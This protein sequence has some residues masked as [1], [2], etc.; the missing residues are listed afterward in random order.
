MAD[1]DR[2]RGLRGVWTAL[3]EAF[4]AF[5][6]D[7]VPQL[8]AALAFSAI[9]AIA[10]F[11]IIAIALGSLFFGRAEVR[12]EILRQ[13][14]SYVGP[15]AAEFVDGLIA[16]A[17]APVASIPAA[18]FGILAVLFTA[19]GLFGLLQLTLNQIWGVKP[20]PGGGIKRL[21][22]TRI[23]SFLMVLALGVLILLTLGTSTA[24]S[25]FTRLVPESLPASA[26]LLELANFAA[27][28]V[29]TTVA[30]ALIY[31]IL[32][33]VHLSF[34]DVFGGALI[35]ALIFNVGQILIGLYIAYGSLASIYGAA[36]SLV[37]ILIW[38]YFSAQVF[39]YGAELTQVFAR[40][41]GSKM[42]PS[43]NAQ[44]VRHLIPVKP[45]S[46]ER[47]RRLGRRRTERKE[48]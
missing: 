9:F 32:P 26:F 17:S 22:T 5:N 14:A 33:D 30:F 19:M 10:P 6:E 8:A 7:N 3:V 41:R 11:A 36:G 28:V 20:K 21:L 27:S 47:M 25:A 44:R 2:N 45:I 12:A 35:T 24:V 43:G 39:L 31:M 4:G 16:E 48:D 42:E 40:R 23:P 1:E 13:A 38:V 15:Q 29:V 37:V 18:I 34:A 46:L